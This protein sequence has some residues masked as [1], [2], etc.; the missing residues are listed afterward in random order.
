MLDEINQRR[1]AS[2]E[3]IDQLSASLAA[4]TQERDRRVRARE[5]QLDEIKQLLQQARANEAALANDDAM[6]PDDAHGGEESLKQGIADAR[7]ELAALQKAHSEDEAKQQRAM[8]KEEEALQSLTRQYDSVMSDLIEKIKVASVEVEQREKETA[9]LQAAYDDL[10][11]QRAPLKHEEQN[12]IAQTTLKNKEQ[13]DVL[14]ATTVWQAAIRRYLRTA[15]KIVKKKKKD[16][17]H[18]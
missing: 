12:Y 6:L 9:E 3:Y 18:P 11:R 1:R 8:R 15:P 4:A 13:Q 14:A 17:K 5:E 16:R 7:A 10:E 2:R